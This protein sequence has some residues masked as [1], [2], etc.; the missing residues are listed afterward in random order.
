MSKEISETLWSRISF[1]LQHNEKIGSDKKLWLAYANKIHQLDE[2]LGK[3]LYKEF[4][5]IFMEMPE[6]ESI[7]RVRRKLHEA[8]LFLENWGKDPEKN[9]KEFCESDDF[10]EI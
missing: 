3:V 8:G 5:K 10:V 4:E 6:M 7:V 2:K 1:L 9:L